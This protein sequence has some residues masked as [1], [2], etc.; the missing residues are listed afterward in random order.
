M[1]D[2]LDIARSGLLAYRSALSVTA[3]NVAN[4]NT[5]GYMRRTV[6]TVAAAGARATATSGASGGQGVLLAD[7]RRAFDD[8]AADRV[9]NARGALAAAGAQLSGAEAIETLML[10]GENGV[11]GHLR[12]FFDAVS[13]LATD[14]SQGAART[15]VMREGQAVAEAISDI[16]RG[17]DSLRRD[18]V[19]SAERG[20]AAASAMLRELADLSRRSGGQIGSADPALADRRDALLDRLADLLPIRVTLSGEGQ[21][22][23]RLG[24]PAGPVLLEGSQT[25]ILSVSV[26]DLLS[27]RVQGPGGTMAEARV[28]ARGELGGIARA[29]GAAEM[30]SQ[31]L[32]GFAR[33]FAQAA[34]AV[35]RTGVDLQGRPG[36]DLF[37]VQGWAVTPAAANSGTVAVDLHRVPGAPP[38]PM[39]LVY[40]GTTS[41]WVA[42]D[43]AGTELLRG[44]G[45]LALPGVTVDLAGSPGDGDRL[46]LAPRSGQARDMSWIAEGASSLA[47][48]AALSATAD[49]SNTG[50]ARFVAAAVPDPAGPDSLPQ[51]LNDGP[52]E[53]SAGIVGLI[54]AGSRAV[55]L[56]AAGR[57]AT[58]AFVSVAGASHLELT[59]P[60]GLHRFSLASLDGVAGIAGA[61]TEGAVVSDRGATLAS[62]GL[63]ARATDAGV[64]QIHRPGNTSPVAAVLSGPGLLVTGIGTPAVPAGSALQVITRDGRHV[65]GT[66]LSATQAAALITPANGF[67]AGATYDASPLH[68]PAGYRGLDADMVLLPGEYQLTLAGTGLATAAGLPMPESA[69]RTITL[70]GPDGVPVQVALPA[71]TNA[72]LASERLRG[73][74]PGLVAQPSTSVELSE[75]PNGP[76]SMAIQGENIVPVGV[77]AEIVA[78]DLRPLGQA[79][80]AVSGGT[81]IVAEASPDGR[82]LLLRQ[83][84][85]LDITASSLSP[86]GGG[87][88]RVTPTG[89]DGIAS[90]PGAVLGAGDAFRQGGQINLNS[91]LGFAADVG[92]GS[93]AANDRRGPVGLHSTA[94]GAH[95]RA[96]FPDLPDGHGGGV[97]FTLSVA[98]RSYIAAQ[99]DGTPAAGV[100]SAMAQSLRAGAPDAV[101]TGS[102]LASLP[103][104]GSLMHLTVD[105]AAYTLRI[106]GGQPVIHGP[107]PSRLEATFDSANRLVITA[108]GVTDGRG[109]VASAATAMGFGPGQGMLRL[110]GQPPDPGNLPAPVRVTHGG[111]DWLLSLGVGSVT[112]PP[113]F[114][115]LASV[116]ASTGALRID[117]PSDAGAFVGP[118][119]DAGL[120]GPGLSV[121]V[122][123]G[124]LVLAGPSQA[125]GVTVTQA[126]EPAQW[127]NLRDVPPE[128]LIVALTGSGPAILSG[129]LDPGAVPARPGN[130]TLA[131]EDAETRRLVLR[132][133][134]TGDVIARGILDATGRATLGGLSVQLDGQMASGDRFH[135][136]RTGIVSGD[137]S[138]A[139]ALAALRALDP[140]TAEPGMVDRLSRLQT[141]TGTRAAAAQQARDSAEATEESAQR[142]VAALGGVDLDA[143]A[144]R[145]I[146]LQQ[147]YQASAQAMTVARDLFDTLISLF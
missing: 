146:E 72:A 17:L 123:G 101:L 107:E 15:V 88:M 19:T 133:T 147:A 137:G 6:G 25:A 77:A 40:D 54:A 85:G 114:P 100:A 94:A 87:T 78:G 117:L 93:M 126:G 31:E 99:P 12:R 64:L 28:L 79:I 130:V 68:A 73:A 84:A 20:A 56:M 120:G 127:M 144:A 4:V 48:A 26:T 23:V 112:V 75:L 16:G 135:L 138:V 11:D 81:G 102:P 21:P 119:P 44:R 108:R 57:A 66:P 111:T 51:V 45:T 74:L 43:E 131:V 49:A 1:R 36:G 60:D 142:A 46:F 61:L 105:D 95:V 96:D 89:A 97:T 67:R 30:A 116:D 128:D 118:A 33:R 5:E 53:R 134:P 145:L 113:G 39:D 110:T 55:T 141:D 91:P 10:P 143:E 3:D 90:G 9:R 70:A 129:S 69:G 34:N 109:I 92:G 35:H 98:G 18:L 139:R 58:T 2:M 47:A 122:S 62:L 124:T 140:G 104:D 65:A 121:R 7:V 103:P 14:P 50:N 132:D 27:L 76:F 59:L 63:T 13:A 71:G 86:S 115:G 8:L 24:G 80:N 136:S 41:E 52:V 83:I 32:D 82:R 29:L 125:L 37:S 22:T 42:F 38:A 106:Q